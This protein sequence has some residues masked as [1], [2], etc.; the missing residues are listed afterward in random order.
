MLEIVRTAQNVEIDER[1][2]ISID[3]ASKMSGRSISAIAAMLERGTLPWYQFLPPENEG[4][5]I[6][7]FTSRRAVA[8]LTKKRR[9]DKHTRS[10]PP[11]G[12]NVS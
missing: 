2:L 3:E 9:A 12:G 10:H 1:E 7:R 5:R 6:Q 4:K 11:G 8:Q